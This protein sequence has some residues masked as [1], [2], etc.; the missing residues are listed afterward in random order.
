MTQPLIAVS[1]NRFPAE[2]RQFYRGKELEYGE[3][4][5]AEAIRYAGGLPMMTY[6]AGVTDPDAAVRHAEA[7]FDHCTALVLTG[8][9]DVS[10]ELYQEAAMEEA[11]AGDPI[12]DAWELTLLRVAEKRGLPI[13]AICRGHQLLN[14]HRGGS[15]YQDLGRLMPG[16]LEHRSQEKYCQLTHPLLLEEESTISQIFEGEELIVN[17]VHHQAVRR[18]GK[19]LRVTARAPDGT[20][21]GIEDTTGPWIVGVQW[22]P[23]WMPDARSKERLF[24]MLIEE[25]KLR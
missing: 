19:N 15:L 4:Q 12:R 1:P 20:V 25:A 13:L 21:E 6:R 2:E 10:P 9:M 22:H 18:L 7:I 11:W 5:M 16:S 17:S 8:G 23:E 3:S 14:V 24:T